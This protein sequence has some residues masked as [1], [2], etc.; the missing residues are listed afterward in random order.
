[1]FLETQPKPNTASQDCGL[2]GVSEAEV[3]HEHAYGTFKTVTEAHTGQV[4]STRSGGNRTFQTCGACKRLLD[5]ITPQTGRDVEEAVL[6]ARLGQ[7]LRVTGDVPEEPSYLHA[8]DAPS[9]TGRRG[10]GSMTVY[11]GVTRS[12]TRCGPSDRPLS[13]WEVAGYSA[14]GT[15]R[16]PLWWFLNS[17]HRYQLARA[18]VDG[19]HRA[20]VTPRNHGGVTVL[21]L[22]SEF[23]KGQARGMI[24]I[25]L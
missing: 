18:Y 23:M 8:G 3:W 7:L 22:T 2:C 11:H 10:G 20:K 6:D 1:M 15:T 14:L 19:Y 17:P 21:G 16:E 9:H 25:P 12:V 5:F 13:A 4:I 24:D